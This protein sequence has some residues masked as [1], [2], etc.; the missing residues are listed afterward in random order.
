MERGS[1][2]EWWEPGGVGGRR[3][4][5]DRCLFCKPDN[6][7][8]ISDAGQ[9]VCTPRTPLGPELGVGTGKNK[10]TL[11]TDV[12]T[13]TCLHSP[14]IHTCTYTHAHAHTHTHTHTNALHDSPAV[15]LSYLNDLKFYR[16]PT[17]PIYRN[18][19][20]SYPSLE[21]GDMIF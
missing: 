14:V 2:W 15:T 4:C 16:R 8:L 12:E 3:L 10:E 20:I 13:N 7:I 5:T 21:G 1:Q 9:W 19:S 17:L 11:L 6:R 18:F